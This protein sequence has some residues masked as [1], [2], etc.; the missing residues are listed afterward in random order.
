MIVLFC[1]AGCFFGGEVRLQSQTTVLSDVDCE[2]EKAAAEAVP[3]S[4]EADEAPKKR[5]P[6][7]TSDSFISELVSDRE[8][9][10]GQ[11]ALTQAAS[12][13]EEECA[14]GD[15]EGK[16]NAAANVLLPS[17][18]SGHS[19]HQWSNVDLEEA[20][21]HQT[22]GTNVD[23][24]DTCSLSSVATF[25][26]G[27]EEPYGPDDHPLWAWVSG[28]GCYIDSHS[29]LHWF[30]STG[31]PF[32]SDGFS[33]SKFIC[34]LPIFTGFRYWLLVMVVAAQWLRPWLIT[35]DQKTVSLDPCKFLNITSQLSLCVKA[36]TKQVH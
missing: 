33:I 29:Q 28:G 11:R 25:N 26:L 15:T 36:S 4:S 7:V 20:Q 24:A 19:D 34:V 13:P 6:K 10:I 16:E 8:G 22:V 3:S 18:Q 1:S 12:I 27:M 5:I 23:A 32:V 9:Q 2:P 14:E 31:Q 30:N 21:T 35:T 17:S